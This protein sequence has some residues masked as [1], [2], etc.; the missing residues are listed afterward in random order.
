MCGCVCVCITCHTHKISLI[1]FVCI[2]KSEDTDTFILNALKS[3]HYDVYVEYYIAE[4][5]ADGNIVVPTEHKFAEYLTNKQERQ[6]DLQCC[7]SH[8]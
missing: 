7:G 5:N 3:I 2:P 6:V 1:T 4:E 8:L